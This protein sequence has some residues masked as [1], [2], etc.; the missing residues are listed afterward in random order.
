[1]AARGPPSCQYSVVATLECLLVCSILSDM[2]CDSFRNAVV[3]VI[4]EKS[5]PEY[6]FE[7][8]QTQTKGRQSGSYT[9]L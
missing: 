7:E 5:C 9:E 1:M 2:L 4:T 6:E 8:E 3:E